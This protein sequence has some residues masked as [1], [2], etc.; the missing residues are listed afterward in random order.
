M[1]TRNFN[2]VLCFQCDNKDMPYAGMALHSHGAQRAVHHHG[3]VAY[4]DK[5]DFL[6]NVGM[7]NYHSSFCALVFL[8]RCNSNEVR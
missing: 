3:S 6:Y 1:F 7:S 4:W 2:Y 8:H 5:V